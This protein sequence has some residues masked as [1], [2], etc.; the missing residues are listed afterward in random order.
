MNIKKFIDVKGFMPFHEGEALTKWASFFSRNGPILEIGSYCGK[1][2][3]FLA[4]GAEKNNQ[5][6]FTVDHH[7][8]SEEHQLNEEYFD[9]EIFDSSTNKINSLP[10]LI[11]NINL[12]KVHNIVPIIRESSEAAK[13]WNSQLSMVFID[14]SHS[15]DSAMQDFISWNTKITSGGALVIHDIYENP[16]EGGQAPYRVYKHALKTGFIDFERVDTIVCL[17][18]S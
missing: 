13:Y 1:S 16:E 17:K 5:Y 6:I 8:G 7:R 11:S 14:G 10:M 12:Y 9:A 4:K 2:S 3:L 15:L 18:K